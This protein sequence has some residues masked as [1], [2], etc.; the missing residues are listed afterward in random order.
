MR[1]HD[2]IQSKGII[3]FFVVIDISSKV[4]QVNKFSGIGWIDVLNINEFL[5]LVKTSH[6]HYR[7]NEIVYIKV[8]K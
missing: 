8:N 4:I 6:Y 2:F 5:L 1:L 3:L 7:V